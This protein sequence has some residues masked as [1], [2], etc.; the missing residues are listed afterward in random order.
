MWFIQIPSSSLQSFIS[1]SKQKGGNIPLP[2]RALWSSS[3]ICVQVS[4]ICHSALNIVTF[5]TLSAFCIS[6][7]LLLPH[8]WVEGYGLQSKVI[9][10]APL[11][12]LP[13]L[14]YEHIPDTADMTPWVLPLGT[15]HPPSTSLIPKG[16]PVAESLAPAGWSS[17]S[18]EDQRQRLGLATPSSWVFSW[19]PKR[20]RNTFG[21]IDSGNTFSQRGER[22]VQ[23]HIHTN[24]PKVSMEAL[25]EKFVI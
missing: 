15:E 21:P 1:S 17:L 3:G 2:G 25:G 22:H 13:Q 9:L 10:Q 7:P 23:G 24:T 16:T 4:A 8:T 11:A 14:Q 12:P 6:L 19:H 20:M 18:S 5:S